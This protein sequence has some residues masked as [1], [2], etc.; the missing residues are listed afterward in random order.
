MATLDSPA[1]LKCVFCLRRGEETL[2]AF[3]E[4]AHW[5]NWV[6]QSTDKL[7]MLQA[8]LSPANCDLRASTYLKM[9]PVGIYSHHL[10]SHPQNSGIAFVE[11]SKQK[12]KT[13]LIPLLACTRGRE[14]EAGG[15]DQG[16]QG[17]RGKAFNTEEIGSA[18]DSGLSN[19]RDLKRMSFHLYSILSPLPSQQGF[20][21]MES[22]HVQDSSMQGKTPPWTQVMSSM[23]V[24]ITPQSSPS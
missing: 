13:S 8:L 1:L 21:V 14:H 22:N 6:A 23:L 9:S 7:P 5:F 10:Q 18:K 3:P 19:V 17:Q 4:D 2:A 12:L 11:F 15:G 16:G 20:A 24:F